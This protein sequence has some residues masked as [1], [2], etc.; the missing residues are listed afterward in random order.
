MRNLLVRLSNWK[1]ILP[2]LL[3]FLIFAAVLFP[4]YQSRMSEAAGQEIAPLDSRFS[5]TFDEVRDSFDALGTEGRKI[6]RFVISRIDMIFPLFYGP[7]FILV[8]AWLLK[9]ISGNGSGWILLALFPLIGILFEYLENFNTLSMLDNYPTITN[10]AVAWGSSMTSFKQVFLMLSVALI[11]TLAIV[12]AVK[13][14][15]RRRNV[16]VKV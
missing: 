9:K 14:L 4:Q 15:I 3:L 16:G 8:L 7:L 13:T 11:A 12:L 2:F 5:Y 6:Y 10:E 1:F